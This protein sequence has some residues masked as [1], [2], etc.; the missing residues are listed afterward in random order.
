MT[1]HWD[2]LYD[3]AVT[4]DLT[5]SARLSAPRSKVISKSHL[6][7]K[8]AHRK[9][10]SA[11][12]SEVTDQTMGVRL[13]ST[14]PLSLTLKPS[15]ETKFRNR[16]NRR[17]LSPKPASGRHI[18]QMCHRV[19]T[20]GRNVLIRFDLVIYCMSPLPSNVRPSPERGVRNTMGCPSRLYAP[21]LLAPHR[22][23]LCLYLGPRK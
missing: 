18:S 10:R 19:S 14:P 6:A 13:W 3:S 22:W 20:L 7:A 4:F 12:R 21:E 17:R 11:P 8:A 2:I 16:A 23:V 15:S 5:A 1:I 9:A